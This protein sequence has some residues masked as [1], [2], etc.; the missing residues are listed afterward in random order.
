MA[1]RDILMNDVSFAAIDRAARLPAWFELNSRTGSMAIPSTGASADDDWSWLD[2]TDGGV[3][4]IEHQ[5]PVELV[6][7]FFGKSGAASLRA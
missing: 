7:A 4:V 3:E 1:S 6:A 2:T 5:V